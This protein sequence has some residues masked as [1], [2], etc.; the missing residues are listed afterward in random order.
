MMED[1]SYTVSVWTEE[2]II[3]LL[4]LNVD[5]SEDEEKENDNTKTF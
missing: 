3:E 1:N 2:E 5:I 4:N